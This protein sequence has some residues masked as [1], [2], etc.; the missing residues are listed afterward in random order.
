[1]PVTLQLACEKWQISGARRQKGPR[2][3]GLHGVP[4]ATRLRYCQQR[5]EEDSPQEKLNAALTRLVTVLTII[6]KTIGPR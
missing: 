2:N 3:L 5:T 1:M 6:I 4:E